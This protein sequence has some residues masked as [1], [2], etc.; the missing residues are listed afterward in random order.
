ME[1]L[2]SRANVIVFNAVLAFWIVGYW[3][4]LL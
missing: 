2:V 1:L 3:V 4:V